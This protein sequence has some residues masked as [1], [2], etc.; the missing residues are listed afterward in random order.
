[1]VALLSEELLSILDSFD[2][3]V[4]KAYPTSNVTH[5]KQLLL[6]VEAVSDLI[7]VELDTH[8]VTAPFVKILTKFF[9]YLIRFCKEV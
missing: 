8:A 7:V 9:T 6:F 4:L 3:P 2:W 1:M 5:L